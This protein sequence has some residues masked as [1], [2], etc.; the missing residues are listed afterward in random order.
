MQVSG[1][2]ANFTFQAGELL[3]SLVEG[4]LPLSLFHAP[5]TRNLL[6]LFNFLLLQVRQKLGHLSS[7]PHLELPDDLL[8][9]RVL[10]ALSPSA[11]CRSRTLLHLFLRAR[12]DVFFTSDTH[13]LQVQHDTKK[14]L[15]LAGLLNFEIFVT[16]DEH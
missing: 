13:V 15:D 10:T 12:A 11:T 8:F 14:A 6:N 4:L 5:I 1:F 16:D 3:D 9:D 2:L 7:F